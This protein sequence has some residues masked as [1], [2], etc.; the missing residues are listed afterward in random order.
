MIGWWMR[1]NQIEGAEYTACIFS[2]NAQ[3]EKYLFRSRAYTRIINK[4]LKIL[5]NEIQSPK[6][7]LIILQDISGEEGDRQIPPIFSFL[8]Y[9]RT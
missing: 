7:R 2:V 4:E 8:F 1:S 6:M 3:K 9:Y 5:E